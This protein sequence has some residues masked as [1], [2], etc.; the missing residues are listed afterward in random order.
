MTPTAT[1]VPALGGAVTLTRMRRRHLPG[2]LAIEEA[3]YPQP[4]SQGIFLTELAQSDTRRYLV[5][6]GSGRRDRQARRVLGYAG[7]IMMVDEAHV[8]TVAVHPAHHRRKIA[9]RLVLGLL[10]SARDLGAQ[11]AT[12]E[13]RLANRGAQRLYAGFG[14]AP[15]GIRPGYYADTGEDA[16]IMWLHELASDGVAATLADQRR[17]LDEP[18]GASGAPDLHVPWVRGRVALGCGTG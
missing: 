16:L 6:Q 3:C 17:R 2:V 13:V 8:S 9:T 4:W 5:A 11:A 12:L 7:V 10:E 15:V 18:G 1:S 14:F